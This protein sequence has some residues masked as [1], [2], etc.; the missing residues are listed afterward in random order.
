MHEAAD[1]AA[2]LGPR[3]PAT[4]L[5]QTRLAERDGK[6]L[7]SIELMLSALT[8]QPENPLALV[9]T[10]ENAA[11]LPMDQQ[12]EILDRLEQKLLLTPGP[13]H[14]ARDL[15]MSVAF[16][17]GAE[18][19]LARV[20]QWRTQRPND[21]EL[22]QAHAAVLLGYGQGRTDAARAAG[23]LEEAVRRF[24]QHYELR[25]SLANAYG[26]LL[27]D[28]RRLEMLREALSRCPLDSPVRAALASDLVRAGRQNEA[29]ALLQEGIESSPQDAECWGRRAEIQWQ[30]GDTAGA[31][32][33]LRKALVLLPE[34]IALRHTLASWLNES[35]DT[36][37]ALAVVRDGLKLYPESATLWHMLAEMMLTSP[38]GHNLKKAENALRKSL[39]CDSSYYDAADQ[40]AWLLTNN[41]RFGEARQVMRK[42]IPRL[43]NPAAALGRLAWITWTR[44]KKKRKAIDDMVEVL[45]AHPEYRWG[46]WM[47]MDWLGEMGDAG[48]IRR[49]LEDVPA[50]VRANPDITAKR[51]VLLGKMASDKEKLDAEWA[52]AIAD[53]PRNEDLLQRRFDM[54][55][56]QE[57]WEQARQEIERGKAFCPHAP[58]FLIRLLRMALHDN[59]MDLAVRTA[60]EM[61][62]PHQP[63][64]LPQA[65]WDLLSAA[66]VTPAAQA[67][68]D[69][70][71][72]GRAL[73]REA[74]GWLIGNAK[75]ITGVILDGRSCDQ[76]Q[77][78]QWLAT[79]LTKYPFDKDRRI[80]GWTLEELNYVD[81]GYVQRF[82]DVNQELCK[83]NLA[84]WQAIAHHLVLG[85]DPRRVRQ[86]IADWRQREGV[87]M[88]Y[89]SYFRLSFRDLSN[90]AHVTKSD[91]QAIYETSRDVL[92]KLPEDHSVQFHV[93]ALCES[94]LAMGRTDEFMEAAKKY[95][96]ILKLS[97]PQYAFAD[98]YAD[99]LAA[100]RLVKLSW[101]LECENPV[102][103]Q[104]ILNDLARTPRFQVAYTAAV[105][106]MKKWA[107]QVPR[108]FVSMDLAPALP[109]GPRKSP[110]TPEGKFLTV[111]AV[112]LA[113]VPVLGLVI[114]ILA[115]ANVQGPKRKKK[116]PNG[117]KTAAKV[118]MLVGVGS[119]VSMFIIALSGSHG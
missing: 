64:G 108:P 106:Y 4:L 38:T 84:L 28:D 75:N 7:E 86:W 54:L 35:G 96:G 26:T 98:F 29:L 92:E 46:W 81:H 87:Q 47:L 40:L 115:Y 97:D 69:S 112:I 58:N 3:E 76:Q 55:A 117:W 5:L 21:P 11:N 37:A 94:L 23:D 80:L 6:W 1:E 114:S 10:W 20:Q 18:Q 66:N 100:D 113:M 77:M 8:I 41:L 85:P 30:F 49:L 63:S 107:G 89:V 32:E 59:D 74:L 17:L 43:S 9:R 72:A 68:L 111:A 102:D 15:A 42:H 71:A 79:A 119:T 60:T 56:D 22:I 50:A 51:L 95:R 116:V 78:L 39:E 57:Q 105:N 34:N 45:K 104:G 27:K 99:A 101:L 25:L 13:L 19:A 2:R 12:R 110:V 36:P 88:V 83:S 44:G 65:A 61:F 24:P 62:Q 52:K 93:I 118:A 70:V 16:R 33:T 90:S 82:L 103:A 91:W 109:T 31:A 14:Q 53:F 73:H 67:V 48:L